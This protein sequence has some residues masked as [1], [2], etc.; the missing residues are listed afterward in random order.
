VSFLKKFNQECSE[1]LLQFH[2]LLVAEIAL[3]PEMQER[4]AI[5]AMIPSVNLQLT[6]S[7]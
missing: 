2:H 5:R 1:K 4:I 3:V 6:Q 7:L